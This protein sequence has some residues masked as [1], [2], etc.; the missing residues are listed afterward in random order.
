MLSLRV[1]LVSQ[2]NLFTNG[3]HLRHLLPEGSTRPYEPNGTASGVPKSPA[4][5]GGKHYLLVERTGD[6]TVVRQPIDSDTNLTI[7]SAGGVQSIAAVDSAGRQLG[8]VALT[9]RED[10]SHSP[11]ARR[12][13]IIPRCTT[14]CSQDMGLLARV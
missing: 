13:I 11:V 7:D 8:S 5:S 14:D 6:S 1:Q 3:G 12:S 10:G 4:L 2:T 9:L